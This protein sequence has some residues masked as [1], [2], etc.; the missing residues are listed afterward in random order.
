LSL[1]NKEKDR[2]QYSNYSFQRPSLFGGGFSFFPPVIKYLL[3]S[4]VVIFLLEGL[5]F[6][7]FRVGSIPLSVWFERY[8]ALFPFANGFLP[9]QLF[10]YMFMHANFLHLFFNMFAL[11]MFGMELE[12]QWGSK[13]FLG[14]YLLCGISAGVSHLVF[15]PMFTPAA[16]TIGASG[17]VYGILVAFGLLFPN[18]PIF[19]Y[20]LLPI[21]AK[22]FVIMYMAIELISIGNTDGIAH[23]AHLGGAV[24]GLIFLLITE[25]NFN[26]S[27]IFGRKQKYSP[28]SQGLTYTR[29]R[30]YD[31]FVDVS[32]TDY[33]KEEKDEVDQERI[34]D[35]LDKINREGYKSLTE[36]EKRILFEASKKIQ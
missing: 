32:D 17:A 27:S 34:D 14:Y 36:E 31:K 28:P 1:F 24:A 8:F 9:W 13:K 29:H 12:N 33:Y 4:N 26:L 20:F 7:G 23:F 25:G 22:Y 6:R 10:T 19:L 15:A 16:P 18:R 5:F 35:I 2:Y 11:W 3:V 30:Y 21:K